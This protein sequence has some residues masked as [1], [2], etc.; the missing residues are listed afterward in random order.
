MIGVAFA[1]AALIVVLSVFNGLEDLLRSL[2][3]SFDPQ[4]KIE[5][6]KGK[7]FSVDST[8]INR[9]QSLAGVGIVTEVI[10]DYGYVRYK[11]ADLVVM[12]KGVTNNF[13]DQHRLDDHI[14]EGQ[15]KLTDKGINYAIIGRGVKYALSINLDNQF[16]LLQVFYIKTL[17]PSAAL[18]PSQLYSQRAIKPGAVFSI[19]KSY[20][21]NYVFLPLEFVRDLTAYG[22][23]RTS[24]EIKVKDGASVRAV[25]DEVRQL[26][27]SGFLVQTNE[28]QHQDLYRL[29]KIEKLFTFLS[30]SLLITIGSLNIFF[31]L[32][33]LA[34]D[35][36]KDV[37][38]LFALGAGQNL[39]RRI[40]L[41]EGAL[42]A[43]V[44]AGTGLVL[45]AFLCWAQARFGL[46]SMG[47]DNAV[48]PNYPVRMSLQ[49]FA[50]VSA[51]VV[52]VTLLVSIYPASRAARFY[53]PQQL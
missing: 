38:I 48:I 29:L 4:L 7:S 6:T 12:I 39:I 1:T 11:D 22:S 5:A 52:M 25:Q 28:E 45:G 47:M 30:L 51:V 14:D 9:I 43:F 3:T 50:S 8:M 31:S 10:E 27:G 17:K 46:V 21:E 2:Y 18:D 35:K 53:S 33:M 37:S 26:L 34:I 42:I 36:K 13:I 20:D 15:L 24:L 32:M 23:K 41:S 16:D 49:D 44:G 40:F 19:E